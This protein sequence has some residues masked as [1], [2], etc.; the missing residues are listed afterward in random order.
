MSTAEQ[1]VD[2]IVVGAGFGGCYLLHKLRESG[3]S[4]K[5]LEAGSTL[6]G[7]W[8]WNRYPGARVDCEFPYYGF[9]DPAIW[10]TFPW[11]ER[12]PSDKELRAYFHH[13]ADVWDLHRNIQLDTRVVEARYQ[14]HQN[15]WHL[16]T[17][18]ADTVWK[19]RWLIAATG[20]SFKQHIP[21]WQGR[22]LFAGA[23]HHSAL[24]PED[25]TLEAKNVAVIGAGSTGVQI[26]QEASNVS[27][28]VTQF[29]RSPNLAL[30]MRQRAI[31]EEERLAYLP[32][33]PHVFRA[34]RS[35]PSGLPVERPGLKV[36]DESAEKRNARLE[37]GWKL[38]GFNWSQGS[39]SDYI[40]DPKANRELYE[41][42]K[43]KI[44][45][46]ISDPAKRDIL[47]PEEPPYYMSTKRPSLEQDYYE[48]CDRPNV[49][50]TDS[51]IVSFTKTGIV[52]ED[53]KERQFDLVAVCT[54][55]DAV[56]GGLRTMGIKGRNGI[57]LDEKWKDGVV[58]NLGM[59]VNGFPNMFMVYGPQAPTSLSNGPIFLE[60][61]GDYIL[62]ILLRQKEEDIE[63][64]EADKEAEQAWRTHCLDLA[65]RTLLVKTN[66]WYMGTNIPGKKREYLVY[67]GGLPLYQQKMEEA[68]ENWQGYAL[69]SSSDATASNL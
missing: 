12:F 33:M 13:V 68:L 43:E 61:Q 20:T 22:E 17:K 29:I 38:G 67:L 11:T 45:A 26:V 39:Y 42:W 4:V 54:G 53:G 64:I 27:P 1:E 36:F 35:T 15:R 25:M 31:T 40:V 7:V 34:C 14:E 59:L 10:R 58:T 3:F 47:A 69:S 2:V 24:W 56:T 18:T 51:P 60:M 28:R 21:E 46:R 50:I 48:S 55:Y 49:E 37:H 65:E 62:R 6:G 63:S 9:S 41:F 16:K 52:T 44:R 5:V 57:D 66:S 19:C 23:L 8:C 30:P 32:Q